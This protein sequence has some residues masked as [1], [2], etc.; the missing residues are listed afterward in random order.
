MRKDITIEAESRVGRGKNEANRLRAKGLMPAVLYGA[1]KDS[2]AVSVSPKE[3]TRI[4]HSSTGHNTIFNLH[5]AA[6]ENTPAMVVDWLNDPV[7]ENL[8]HV[9]LLRIDLTK[10]IKVK[11]PVHFHGD[12]KGVKQQGGIFEVVM[13]EV[14]V[15]CLPDDIPENFDLDISNVELNQSIRAKDLPLTASMKLLEEPEA[16][17]AHVVALKAEAAPAEGADVAAAPGTEPEVIK[18]GK[19]E[20]AAPEAGGDKKKK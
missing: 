11:V 17:V 3:V 8:L 9:D 19:K 15:E 16:V 1:G 13:R 5:V 4:L 14:Q 2:V 6:G 7:K 18:K 12:A 20:E 10:R